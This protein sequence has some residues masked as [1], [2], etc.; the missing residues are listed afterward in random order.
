MATWGSNFYCYLHVNS[1]ASV[2]YLSLTYTVDL[3]MEV[4]HVWK[5]NQL[6]MEGD[7]LRIIL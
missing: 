2:F 7:T 1:T 6:C 3:S 5:H 4:H